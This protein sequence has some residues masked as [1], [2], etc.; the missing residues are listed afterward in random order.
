MKYLLIKN[1]DVYQPTGRYKA[2]SSLPW[3]KDWTDKEF[4]SG[5]MN[6]TF[7]Q[8]YVY[9]ALC[10]MRGRLGYDIPYDDP[11]WIARLLHANNATHHTFQ[12]RFSR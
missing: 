6:L 8:R 7:F 3:I 1:W 9:D 2:G 10:R 4:D 12:R 11:K 5:F